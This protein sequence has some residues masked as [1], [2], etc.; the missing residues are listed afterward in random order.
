[1]RWIWMP[2]AIAALVAALWLTERTERGASDRARQHREEPV[3]AEHAVAAC[4][5]VGSRAGKGDAGS[6]EWPEDYTVAGRVVE[7]AGRPVPGAKVH[8]RVGSG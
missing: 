8:L 5:D 3:L 6:A 4:D 2:A 1:M 7:S